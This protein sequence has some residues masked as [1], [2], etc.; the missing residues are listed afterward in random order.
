MRYGLLDEQSVVD[1]ANAYALLDYLGDVQDGVFE[2][3]RGAS[4]ASLSM[5]PRCQGQ[6]HYLARLFAQVRADDLETDLAGQRV[7]RSCGSTPRWRRRRP[8]PRTYLVAAHL[9]ALRFSID[10]LLRPAAAPA[11]R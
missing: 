11:P 8:R 6:R 10:G 7:P 2:E 5:G 3:L 1:P 4:G 9:T